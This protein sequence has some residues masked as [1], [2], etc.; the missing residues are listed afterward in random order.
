[1]ALP[2]QIPRGVLPIHL[3]R[4]ARASRLVSID[5]AAANCRCLPE[6]MPGDW[7]GRQPARPGDVLPSAFDFWRRT[8][9]ALRLR[10][11]NWS[12]LAVPALRG[13]RL[14]A[15]DHRRPIDEAIAIWGLE[16]IASG[17]MTPC[18]A[19]SGQRAYVAMVLCRIPNTCC[20][21]EPLNN[22]DTIM[23]LEMMASCAA[24]AGDENKA[25]PVGGR[26]L[27]TSNSAC[28]LL[29]LISWRCAMASWPCR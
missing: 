8:T 19:G 28:L 22:I 10:S 24:R 11:A 16:P 14:S 17:N 3:D 26:A 1:M 5:A 25:R 18:P 21:D 15:E 12:P 7:H 2:L 6:L 29:R 4:T 27:Q 20:S 23:L 9:D 13:G